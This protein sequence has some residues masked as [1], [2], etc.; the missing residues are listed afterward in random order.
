MG[1]LL[2]GLNPRLPY[3]NDYH[4]YISLLSQKLTTS[5]A[6]IVLLEEEARRGRNAA[7][8]AAYDQAMLKEKLAAQT[9]EANESLQM[10]QTVAEFVPVGMCFGDLEGNIS[11]A[12]DAWYKI[13]GYPGTGPV[14]RDG[15]LAW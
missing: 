12:N 10:F 9:R 4:Q 11:F 8:E 14:S 2:L 13:T 5:L 15:F 7:E 3:G 1:L 6:S